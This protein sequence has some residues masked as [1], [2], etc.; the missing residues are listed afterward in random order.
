MKQARKNKKPKTY[1]TDVSAKVVCDCGA[2]VNLL[3]V[4]DF[5]TRC[6]VCGRPIGVTSACFRVTLKEV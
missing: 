1:R 6:P 4:N 5:L 2:V 3:N